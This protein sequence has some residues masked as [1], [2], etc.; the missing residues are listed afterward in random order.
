M[1]LKAIIHN[2]T[3]RHLTVTSPDGNREIM[4]VSPRW[5][6]APF[7]RQRNA[8]RCFGR[9]RPTQP[10]VEYESPLDAYRALDV[11]LRDAP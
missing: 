7:A 3:Y 9:Q 4:I 1:H 11:D 8:I 6:W 5:W 2:V 10:W